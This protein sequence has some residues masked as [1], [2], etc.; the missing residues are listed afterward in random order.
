MIAAELNISYSPVCEAV[1][2][3]EIEGLLTTRPRKGTFVIAMD[4]EFIQEQLIARLAVECQAARMYCG[5][6]LR[7]ERER[8]QQLAIKLD[9]TPIETVEHAIRDTR[10]HRELVRL[11]ESDTLLRIYDLIMR[12]GLLLASF[13][14]RGGSPAEPPIPDDHQRLLAQLSTDEPD[15]AEFM[16]RSNLLHGKQ[17][18]NSEPRMLERERGALHSSPV[19]TRLER[20]MNAILQ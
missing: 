1:L 5:E 13:S 8:L 10:F 17:L 2:Q 4:D 19:R 11:S 14:R 7:R 15:L 16:I 20:N 18:Q 12:Q 6:R 3:L 9:K